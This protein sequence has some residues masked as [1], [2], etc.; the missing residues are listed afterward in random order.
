MGITPTT[1]EIVVKTIILQWTQGSGFE[2]CIDLQVTMTASN[3][4][5]PA[6]AHGNHTGSVWAS[7]AVTLADEDEDL[8]EASG[9]AANAL[10]GQF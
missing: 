3:G 7:N 5:A 6:E 2:L 10:V 4:A 8:M 9:G 1:D